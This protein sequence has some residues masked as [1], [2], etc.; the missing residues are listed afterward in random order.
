MI[1]TAN[2]QSGRE[3]RAMLDS[4]CF[5][6]NLKRCFQP[7]LFQQE[8]VFVDFRL[9]FAGEQLQVLPQGC[10][11]FRVAGIVAVGIHLSLGVRALEV[12]T[13]VVEGGVGIGIGLR[14]VV[15]PQFAPGI[16]HG[17][18]FRGELQ[19]V[20]CCV[21]FWLVE[22]IWSCLRHRAVLASDV[23]GHKMAF[24]LF[25]GIDFLLGERNPMVCATFGA[26]TVLPVKK[27]VNEA[28]CLKFFISLPIVVR[29][30]E[31]VSVVEPS[32]FY[33]MPYCEINAD[34]CNVI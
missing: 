20:R 33:A 7:H 28:V 9:D 25:L 16:H 10:D 31:L 17:L 19:G 27:R 23:V 29:E 30:Q 24:E 34:R 21:F 12:E 4:R 26:D 15:T 8:A 13:D 32:G 6:V 14:V 22:Q 2:R 5:T 1:L 11:E 3:N 18:G